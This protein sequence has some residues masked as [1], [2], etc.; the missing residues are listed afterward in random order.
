MAASRQQ[1]AVASRV[2]V[3]RHVAAHVA[4]RHVLVATAS[5]CV[6]EAP[7]TAA[8]RRHPRAMRAP[9]PAPAVAMVAAGRC[10]AH[11]A[12]RPTARL[13]GDDGWGSLPRQQAPAPTA[14]PHRRLRSCHHPIAGPLP[15]YSQR[16]AAFPCHPPTA[17][18]PRHT[19][20]RGPP[21]SHTR[22]R[23]RPHGHPTGPHCQH[24]GLRVG[25]NDTRAGGRHNSRRLLLL[26]LRRCRHRL[27]CCATAG[28]GA[29]H[30]AGTSPPSSPR[31]STSVCAPHAMLPINPPTM[32]Q[33]HVNNP[34]LAHMNS[35]RRCRF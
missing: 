12:A 19:Q 22:R 23:G 11:P 10:H 13:A 34:T 1:A 17:G 33:T 9:A 20:R 3:V 27:H 29:R 26:L 32:Q 18:P 25:H 7:T 4:G 35:L 8:A 5:H 28:A 24:P 21:C 2:A 16:Q 30:R 6:A 14:A 31:S 15:R